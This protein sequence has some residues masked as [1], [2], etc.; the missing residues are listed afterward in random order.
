MGKDAGVMQ[1]GSEGF[2][3][4]PSIVLSAVFHPFPGNHY[5]GVWSVESDRSFP[6]EFMSY[7]K[8][9]IHFFKRNVL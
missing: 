9:N 7:P 2:R 5:R 4:H 6:N 3:D 8:A 1:V